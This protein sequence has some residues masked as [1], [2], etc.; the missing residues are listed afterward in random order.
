MTFINEYSSFPGTVRSYDERAE[1]EEPCTRNRT[2]NGFSPALGAPTRLRQRLSFTLSFFAQYSELQISP[3]ATAAGA[4]AFAVVRP[5]TSPAPM[6]SPAL[7]RIVRR[8][9]PASALSMLPSGG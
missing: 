3:G 1:I 2:D 6:P 9:T 7:M 5:D 4:S 8:A